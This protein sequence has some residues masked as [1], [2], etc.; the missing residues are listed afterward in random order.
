MVNFGQPM[1]GRD[2]F[3]EKKKVTDKLPVDLKD[4]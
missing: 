2:H 1:P 3:A 4:L